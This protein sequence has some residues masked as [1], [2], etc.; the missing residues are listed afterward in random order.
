MIIALS[1]VPIPHLDSYMDALSDNIPPELQPLLN[2]F[3]DNYV[4]R[5]V[6]RGGGRRSPLFPPEIWSQYDRTIAGQNR[7]NNHAEAAHRR[8]YAELGV[9]HP[10]IWK[11]IDGLKAYKKAETC[12]W[13]N[14]L[15]VILQDGNS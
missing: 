7:T 12:I 8:I 3:E 1:F 11:F 15:L 6:R 2:W 13:N 5:P 4:G 14:W 10:V 9:D